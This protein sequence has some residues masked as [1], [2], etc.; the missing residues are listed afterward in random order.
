VFVAADSASV[1]VEL[2]RVVKADLEGLAEAATVVRNGGLICY[3]TDTVY[4]L[5]CDPLNVSSIERAMMAKGGR[6]KAMPVLVKS[7]QDAERLGVLDERCRRL[8]ERFWPGT[9]TLVVHAKKVVPS[10]LAPKGTIGLRS[11]NHQICLNLIALCSGALVGTSANI[12][13]KAPAVSAEDAVK[14]FGDRV[15]VVLDGGRSP[16][17]VASTVVDLTKGRLHMVR[18]GPISRKEIID[19][20]RG[21]KPR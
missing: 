11:P 6:T 2:V 21:S 17:G 9:L 5:G 10:S 8:A 16:L 12:T 3:P 19:C 1:G 13:G 18:E 14:I 20:L 15:D 4:G 7:I